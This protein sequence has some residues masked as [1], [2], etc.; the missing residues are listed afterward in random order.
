MEEKPAGRR[1]KADVAI[2]PF[3][4]NRRK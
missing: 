1:L 2:C 3:K 4:I